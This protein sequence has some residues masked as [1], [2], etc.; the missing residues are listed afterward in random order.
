[1]EITLSGHSL[2]VADL[3]NRFFDRRFLEVTER[4]REEETGAPEQYSCRSVDDPERM[5]S[6]EGS[7]GFNENLKW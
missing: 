4:C 1:M 3:D 6:T 5:S 2:E 7:S